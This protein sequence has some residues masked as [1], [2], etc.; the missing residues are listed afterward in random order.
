M[1]R[2]KK[3]KETTVLHG[4]KIIP[5]GGLGQIGMNMTAFEKMR[6]N[7]KEVATITLEE[8]TA[9]IEA[10]RESRRNQSIG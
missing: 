5:I 10:D 1:N 3:N 4:V 2:K 6:A 9:Q 8:L 7:G